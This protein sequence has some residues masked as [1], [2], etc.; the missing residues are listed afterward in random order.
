MSQVISRIIDSG[1]ILVRFVFERD[2]RGKMAKQE[3]MKDEEVFIDMRGG[4]SMQ[5]ERYCD[6]NEC[7]KRAIQNVNRFVGFLVFRKNKFDDVCKEHKKER[8]TFEA[9]IKSTPLD[10]DNREIPEDIIVKNDDAGNPSHADLSYI[11]PAVKNDESP[12]TALR[13]FSRRLC[14]VSKLIL[15]TSTDNDKFIDYKFSEFV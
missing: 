4:V 1:E 5:R 15:D 11:N 8:E 10:K 7:K 9:L 12:K 14:K 2:F 3:K 13:F 6:E